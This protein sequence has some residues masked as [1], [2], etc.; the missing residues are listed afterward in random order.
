MAAESETIDCQVRS[1]ARDFSAKPMAQKTPRWAYM[2]SAV[3]LTVELKLAASSEKTV[4]QDIAAGK[5]TINDAKGNTLEWSLSEKDSFREQKGVAV[6]KIHTAPQGDWVEIKGSLTAQL[7]GDIVTHPAQGVKMGEKGK[8]NIPGC[9]I[10]YEWDENDMLELSMSGK[11]NKA[12]AD[13]SFKTPAG[14]SVEICYT[15]H[16]SGMGEVSRGY[17]FGDDVK[18]VSV[19]VKTYG[20][21][22]SATVPLN[23]RIGFSGELKAE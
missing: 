2:H 14:E 3:P 18:A 19:I 1:I 6:F 11:D 4:I 9:E 7:S 17:G 5:I 23:M 22:K 21:P 16:S 12:I 15:A 10:S 8:L 13:C 20:E